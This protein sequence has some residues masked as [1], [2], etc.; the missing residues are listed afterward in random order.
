MG[1]ATIFCVPVVMS[2]SL[3]ARQTQ[4]WLQQNSPD[5][6]TKDEWPPN[7]PDLHPLDNHVWGAVLERYRIYKPK[8][9]NKAELIF[10]PVNQPYNQNLASV[11]VRLYFTESLI[12]I[13]LS[14]FGDINYAMRDSMLVINGVHE[15]IVGI[16]FVYLILNYTGNE[17]IITIVSIV[18]LSNPVY[19]S[20]SSQ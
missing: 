18:I 12:V 14:C 19:H 17:T 3:A 15:I 2:L 4:E 1:F 5:F 11:P 20:Y 9:R 10:F 7:S 6:I 8:P 13:V 16:L